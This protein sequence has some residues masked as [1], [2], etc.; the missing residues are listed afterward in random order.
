MEVSVV[1]SARNEFPNIVHTV[2]S[3]VNDLETFLKPGDFEI[4]IVDNGSTDPQSWRF[5]ME[6]GMFYHRTIR[7][8]HDPIMGNVTARNKGAAIAKGK[9]LF[10]SDAHMSYRV[11]SFKALIRAIDE[12]GGIVHPLVQWMGGYEPSQPSYQYTIKLGEK[13]WGTWNNYVPVLGK[14]FAIPVSG[15][16]CLGMKRSE[17]LELGG[18]NPFFR[19]YGGGELYLDLKWW[20]LG[21]GVSVVPD[22]VGY[23][24]SAGR[25]YSFVQ[26]DL[27]HN[28]MLMAFA[29]GAPAFAERVY[30]RYLGKEGVNPERLTKMYNEALAESSPEKS[31]W[32]SREHVSFY[33]LITSR[34]WDVRNMAEHGAANSAVTV[35]DSTWTR[36]LSG[37][38]RTLFDSSPL[39]AELNALIAGPW[40][41]LVYKGRGE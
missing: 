18:Y 22:A 33:D 4:I 32:S 26:N 16:C 34:P 10:F 41:P 15:H 31:F 3:I 38:A 25:G 37:E 7:V 17:F 1:I 23:H 35:F 13:I 2:H 8:L 11:G 14:S 40:A 28:M 36:S 21:L 19:C 30:L 29:L 5:L 12:R 39:Q 24:L 9:Y 27:I 20:M 6:R